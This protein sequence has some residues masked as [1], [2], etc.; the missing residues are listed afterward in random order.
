LDNTGF[1]LLSKYGIAIPEYRVVKTPREAGEAARKIGFPVAMKILSPS[2]L[3]KSDKEGVILEIGDRAGAEEACGA[4]LRRFS[5]EKIEGV[6]VQRMGGGGAEL[7]VGGK[8]DAQFGQLLMLGIGG[9][10]VE[11]YKDVVFRVCP[12]TKEDAC[13]MI[14]ELKARKILE[15]ARG[16]KPVDKEALASALVSVSKLLEKENP[17][18]FDINPLIADEKGCVAVDVRIL[19]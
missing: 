19:R 7:I 16:R 8:R 3:H 18:E 13:Q 15:G 6:L 10:F 4:L 1:R 5:G 17:S 11:I 14:S 2:A 9:I 12:I